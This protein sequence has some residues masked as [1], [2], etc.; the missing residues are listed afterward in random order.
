[1]LDRLDMPGMAL[2]AQPPSATPITI[3]AAP[4][5]RPQ[6]QEKAMTTP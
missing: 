2:E 6:L 3:S 1:M 4:D 5:T